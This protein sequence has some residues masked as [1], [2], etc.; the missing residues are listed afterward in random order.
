[1]E[2]LMRLGRCRIVKEKLLM[3]NFW[4]LLKGHGQD[5]VFNTGFVSS[6]PGWYF[7]WFFLF[8]VQKYLLIWCLVHVDWNANLLLSLL[9]YRDQFWE[10]SNFL[11]N[12]LYHLFKPNQ[13]CGICGRGK[14]VLKCRALA[15]MCW[16]PCF[17]AGSRRPSRLFPSGP[18][19]TGGK[20]FCRLQ[21]SSVYV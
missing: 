18:Q 2:N 1:M 10:P 7:L 12:L 21:L 15:C 13:C 20:L 8:S 17:L 11:I 19:W 5:E 9:K 16:P 14:E 6:R 3:N 4:A